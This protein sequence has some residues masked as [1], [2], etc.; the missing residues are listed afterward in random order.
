MEDLSL[1]TAVEAH[2]LVGKAA[3]RRESALLGWLLLGILSPHYIMLHYVIQP[4]GKA[5]GVFGLAAGVAVPSR[6]KGRTGHCCV[7]FSVLLNTAK[8][9]S[10]SFVI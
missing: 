6:W 2:G 7:H 1:G 5:A 3:S 9:V 4:W 10:Q 8:H